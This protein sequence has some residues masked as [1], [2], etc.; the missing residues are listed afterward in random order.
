[1]T[2]TTDTPNAKERYKSE[3]RT[4]APKERKAFREALLKNALCLSA[5]RLVCAPLSN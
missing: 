1:M 5:G 3:A 2:L 4:V